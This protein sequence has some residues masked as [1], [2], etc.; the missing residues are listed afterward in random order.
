L[1]IPARK[2]YRA[3]FFDDAFRQRVKSG[4][5]RGGGGV[6]FLISNGSAA[7]GGGAARPAAARFGGLFSFLRRWLAKRL[8]FVKN[9]LYIAGHDYTLAG[10]PFVAGR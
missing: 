1:S 6:Y 10:A 9:V 4:G 7:V 8:V 3:C 5:R 2:T